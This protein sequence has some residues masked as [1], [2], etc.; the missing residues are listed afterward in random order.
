MLTQPSGVLWMVT[1]TSWLSARTNYKKQQ[2]RES[3]GVP[4]H[5][6]HT[7][8]P[9]GRQAG[10]PI[11]SRHSRENCKY[12]IRVRAQR[13]SRSSLRRL[14]MFDVPLDSGTEDAAPGSGCSGALEQPVA[15]L[16]MAGIFDMKWRRQPGAEHDALLAMALADG[17]VSVL[18]LRRDPAAVSESAARAEPEAA[19]EGW[20]A[21]PERARVAYAADK[22]DTVPAG[23]SQQAACR[24]AEPRPA[25]WPALAEVCSSPV[26]EGG[27]MVL[28]VD[29]NRGPGADAAYQL[30]SSMSDGSVAVLQVRWC[31]SAVPFPSGDV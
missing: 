21:G 2:T 30:A 25:S 4:P 6:A 17:R 1:T 29:W 15:A 24:G 20:G 14:Y 23:P 16:D 22:Q 18:G 19:T 28:S 3:E 7:A 13:A 12:N 27:V 5:F 10:P 8:V 9:A 26:A 31:P 11:G